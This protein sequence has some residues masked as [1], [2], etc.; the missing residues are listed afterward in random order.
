MAD[1]ELRSYWEHPKSGRWRVTGILEGDRRGGRYA[2]LNEARDV[3]RIVS[4]RYPRKTM[5]PVSG[6]PVGETGT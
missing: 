4:E 3:T 6:A 5:Q 1:I 2:I